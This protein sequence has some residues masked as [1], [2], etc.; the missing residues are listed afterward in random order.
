MLRLRVWLG[1]HR[2]LSPLKVRILFRG[3]L[4]F[5]SSLI[6]PLR[7]QFR[8]FFN[9]C[10]SSLDGCYAHGAFRVVASASCCVAEIRSELTAAKADLS[11]LALSGV[12]AD[13]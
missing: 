2:R 8:E 9:D 7:N 4:A 12:R 10:E 5:F 3:Q 11:L 1:E 13:W 6:N